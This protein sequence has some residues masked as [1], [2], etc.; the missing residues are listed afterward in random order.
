MEK[1]WEDAWREGQVG[2]DAGDSPPILHRL[3]EEQL[4]PK[5]R[6]LV[7]GCGAGY[8]VVTLAGPERHVVGLD[9]APTAKQRFDEVLA[10]SD[11][12]DDEVT[13]RTGDFFDFSPAEPFDLVW[14]YTF[15]CAIEPNIRPDWARQMSKLIRPGGQLVALLFPIIDDEVT[16]QEMMD[17]GPP[18]PLIPQEIEELLAEDF[19]ALSVEPTDESHQGR[20][21]MEWLARF[22]RREG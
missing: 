8:D 13:Y 22:Q 1:K 15:L 3:V 10:A 19:E 20:Q 11:V 21:G 18:F 5:G 4:L 14:D 17:A 6:A 16:F 7:P 12:A 9:G 2:W